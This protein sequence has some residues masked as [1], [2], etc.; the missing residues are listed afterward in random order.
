MLLQA[1]HDA[2]GVDGVRGDAD[3]RRAPRQLEREERVGGL[4]AMA[5]GKRAVADPYVAGSLTTAGTGS[6]LNPA[7]GM[8][9]SRA[10]ATRR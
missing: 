8:D 3:G 6:H 5:R 2:T 10:F 1:G 4:P 9:F 7:P